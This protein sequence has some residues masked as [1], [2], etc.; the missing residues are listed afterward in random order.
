[1]LSAAIFPGCGGI[2]EYGPREGTPSEAPAS[3]EG[4]YW[5]SGGTLFYGEA[6]LGPFSKSRGA[7]AP[8]THD[9]LTLRDGRY[10]L[11]IPAC[12]SGIPLSFGNSDSCLLEAQEVDCAIDDTGKALGYVRWTIGGL[13]ID[14]ER[15]ALAERFC[16]AYI[17]G[18]I[19][20][21]Q[22]T[23]SFQPLGEGS[24]GE[25]GTKVDRDDLPLEVV[26]FSD[27]NRAWRLDNENSAMWECAQVDPSGNGCVVGEGRDHLSYGPRDALYRM[28]DGRFYIAGYDCY[29]KSPYDGEPIRCGESFQGMADIGLPEAWIYYFNLQGSDLH[30]EVEMH[31]KD[32][33]YYVIVKAPAGALGFASE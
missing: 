32:Y 15:R 4:T 29:V 2:V 17:D 9:Q 33:K 28:N 22:T 31:G 7:T 5:W 3:I 23:S 11:T 6:T 20:C 1:M 8:S 25:A 12:Q 26:N 18:S 19:G 21:G 13:R 30:F 16:I 27:S 14:L 24:A 10:M